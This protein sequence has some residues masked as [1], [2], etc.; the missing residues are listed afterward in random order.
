[1]HLMEQVREDDNSAN[2]IGLLGKRIEITPLEQAMALL[3]PGA[4]R[5]S[6]QW[7]YELN[8][9]LERLSMNPK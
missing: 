4:G 9:V 2:V 1:M 3:Q 6:K 7:W 8:T 5:P